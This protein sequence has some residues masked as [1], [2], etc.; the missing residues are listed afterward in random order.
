VAADHPVA[1]LDGD[2]DDGFD[3]A[4]ATGP[5]GFGEFGDVAEVVADVDWVAEQDT[6]VQV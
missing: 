1:V 3:Q 5:E 2:H 6:R 4:D